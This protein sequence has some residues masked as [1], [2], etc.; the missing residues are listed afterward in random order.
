MCVYIT[1]LQSWHFATQTLNLY[2]IPFIQHNTPQ[3]YSLFNTAS[4]CTIYTYSYCFIKTVVVPNLHH[5]RPCNTISVT[6]M[7]RHSAI[8]YRYREQHPVSMWSITQARCFMG[9]PLI[10]TLL[11][12][13]GSHITI[14]MYYTT[15]FYTILP[16]IPSSNMQ[17]TFTR[18]I[19]NQRS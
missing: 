13:C 1:P 2:C 15:A 10:N 5:N 16:S 6:H 8:Q 17:V 3:T 7:H 18:H 12:L 14:L 4:V 9:K 11:N 19:E